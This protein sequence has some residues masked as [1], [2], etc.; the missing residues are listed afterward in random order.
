MNM[1]STKWISVTTERMEWFYSFKQN[2]I[3]KGLY[4]MTKSKQTTTIESIEDMDWNYFSRLKVNDATFYKPLLKL[5]MEQC[6]DDD[7]YPPQMESGILYSFEDHDTLKSLLEAFIKDNE[8]EVK[9]WFE[10][11]KYYYE[12]IS[13]YRDGEYQSEWYVES[14]DFAAGDFITSK[15]GKYVH[16]YKKLTSNEVKQVT[17]CGLVQIEDSFW[18]LTRPLT[19]IEREYIES[20]LEYEIRDAVDYNKFY[21]FFYND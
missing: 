2:V 14:S 16:I 12:E 3:H 18:Q 9:L 21:D 15:T 6:S 11:A 8:V 17:T 13:V 10:S 1:Y 19:N 7:E 4:I 20:T 5:L